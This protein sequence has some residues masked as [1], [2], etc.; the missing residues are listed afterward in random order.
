MPFAMVASYG[1]ITQTRIV[2]EKIPLEKPIE[3]GMTLK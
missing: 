3:F 2:C 1:P